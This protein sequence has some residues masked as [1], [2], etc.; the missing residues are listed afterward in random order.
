MRITK[1][2]ACMQSI[3]SKM[4][5]L[6]AISTSNVILSKHLNPKNF[7]QDE[8]Q[9]KLMYATLARVIAVCYH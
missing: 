2:L 5:Q 7:I 6:Y 4:T 3:F 8:C 1:V 9:V